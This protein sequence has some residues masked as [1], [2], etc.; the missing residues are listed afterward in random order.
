MAFTTSDS[1]RY[2]RIALYGISSGAVDCKG[3]KHEW[4]LFSIMLLA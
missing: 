4:R 1:F 2:V 3:N